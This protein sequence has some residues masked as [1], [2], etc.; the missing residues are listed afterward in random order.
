M[1]HRGHPDLKQ[2]WEQISV[3]FESKCNDF[4]AK[5]AFEN[6]FGQ[7]AAILCQP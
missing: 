5:N 2:I 4:H 1:G 6:A 3:K 7:M